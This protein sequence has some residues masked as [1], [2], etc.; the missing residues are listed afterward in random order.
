MTVSKKNYPSALLMLNELIA[1]GWN[2]YRALSSVA[3]R[4]KVDAADLEQSYDR[5]FSDRFSF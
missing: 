1:Q 3:R 5:Q 2:F 4:F